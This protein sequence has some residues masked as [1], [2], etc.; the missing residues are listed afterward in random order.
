M[1]DKPE[2]TQD[3]GRE[4]E[5]FEYGWQDEDDLWS[6]KGLGT[7]IVELPKAFSRWITALEAENAALTRER[8]R[9]A[10]MA[11]LIADSGGA[12]TE[13]KGYEQARK[14]AEDYLAGREP[15]LYAEMLRENA[16]HY[17]A[18]NAAL[19]LET[20]RAKAAYAQHLESCDLRAYLKLST[21]K[22]TCGYDALTTEASPNE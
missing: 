17:E 1:N 2:P 13:R 4:W 18:E 21:D 10:A 9:A 3:A 16:H 6:L 19:R 20:L 12:A 7:P 14:A 22:C 15:S 5:V 11:E 8:D